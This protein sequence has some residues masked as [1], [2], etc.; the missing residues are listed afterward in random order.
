MSVLALAIAKQDGLNV[1]TPSPL[2]HQTLLANT[3]A[4]VLAKL[5]GTPVSPDDEE[6]DKP[7]VRE[8]AHVVLMT[9]F[10]LTRLKPEDIR[11]MVVKGGRDLRKFYGK[12]SSFA[13]NIPSDLDK[14]QRRKR[15]Q[16][17][18]DEVLEDWRKCSDKLPQ[19]KEAIKDGATEK[20]LEKAVDVA[21]DAVAAHSI[22]HFFGG[23]HGVAL[24]FVVKVGS[25][26]L[27][28]KDDPY[29]FLN[30]VEKVVD[31]SI[32]SLYVPQWRKLA[33]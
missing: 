15:L 29:P 31:K 17:K 1:V 9:G 28:G 22:V 27:K 23:I 26:M 5:L 3:H 19:L 8:L 13:A 2:A 11:D 21:K 10:D 33:S 4:Q 25:T 16:D 32:G 7:T 6:S 24:A 20:G 18:A 12:L 14:D 30:R